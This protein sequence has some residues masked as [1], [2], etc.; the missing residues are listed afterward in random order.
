MT[1]YNEIKRITGNNKGYA[2]AALALTI[3]ECDWITGAESDD[4]LYLRT[5][6]NDWVAI[7]SWYCD[8]DAEFNTVRGVSVK[9]VFNQ[10]NWK[11]IAI[12]AE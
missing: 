4:I 10:D 12:E 5:Q 2:A 6:D 11:T 1:T 7:P 3:A 8:E 9:L